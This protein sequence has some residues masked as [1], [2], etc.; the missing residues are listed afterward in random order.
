MTATA[1]TTATDAIATSGI[2]I[3]TA[4]IQQR[5]QTHEAY[6]SQWATPA[7]QPYV[8]LVNQYQAALQAMGH[9]AS[10]AHDMAVGQILQVFRM[11]AAVLAYSD[12]FFYCSF[13]A[14]AMV[15]FCFLLS[16]TKAG[17]GAPG[18]H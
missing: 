11:Q 9:V 3:S 15:P 14:F 7:H 10:V 12:V 13:V 8:A 17:G 1:I 4:L 2:A 6:L 16:A 18:A 5:M